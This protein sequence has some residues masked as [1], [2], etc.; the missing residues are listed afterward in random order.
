[1][2]QLSTFLALALGLALALAASTLHAA[3][4]RGT[5]VEN[6]TG[7]PLARA[8]VIAE[9]VGGGLE[10]QSAHTNPSG[11]FEF[12]EL[13]AGTYRISA[14]RLE[15]VPVQYGQKRWYSPG[16]PISLE[17]GDTASLTI[18]MP[19]YGA[20]TGTVRDENDVGLPEHEV[21]VYTNTRPP[22]LLARAVTDDRGM[23]RLFDLRPGSYL[24]RSLAKVFD[25]ESY[26]PTV[27]PESP[28]VD[29]ARAI[30][31]TL[32]EQVDHVDFHPIPGRLFSV[33]GRVN[34]AIQPIVTLS[35]DA[36]TETATIDG[37]GNFSFNPMAPGQYELLAEVP[38]DRI[39]GLAAA[40]QVLTVDR[41]ITDI[42][43]R[44][45]PAAVVQ[46][47]FEDTG[48]HAIEMREIPLL[49]RY[50][51]AAAE[52]KA[53]AVKEPRVMLLPGRWDVALPPTGAYC[54]VGFSG[55]Q[56]GS[57]NQGRTDGW[58][59]I[60]L[61]TGS[62]NVVKFVLSSSPATV[63]GTV[64]NSTGDAVAG[65]PVFIE[66]YDLDPRKRLEPARTVS[67]DAKGRYK[68]DGLAPGVYRALASFD[69]QMP[70]PAQMAAA[71][72][73]TVKVEEGGRAVLDLEEFVIH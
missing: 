35:S 62:Q 25:D 50:K 32:D 49:A 7:Y 10:P 55:P 48:G 26:L 69:Y 16:M 40:F 39:R 29:Q 56:S 12:P 3:A 67:S 30:D 41:D 36:G 23:Y 1:M 71:N 14:A 73:K 47:V 11:I 18:R 19:R 58:N 72:A 45:G 42:P 68:V 6:Q 28:T 44:L 54:V 53:E 8:T 13:P 15:F 22:R 5:V 27:Y 66:P 57:A 4:I 51:N 31:V 24:I 21:A 9:L 2:R 70:D 34:S 59:E 33:S 37:R 17:A 43:I 61:A 65:V 20:I 46:F 63:S 60:L 38:A 52:G 64:K